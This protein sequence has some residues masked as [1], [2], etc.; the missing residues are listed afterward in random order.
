MHQHPK[1]ILQLLFG[2]FCIFIVIKVLV[3]F[4]LRQAQ[5]E[6]VGEIQEQGLDTGALF[7]SNSEE[8]VEANFE[9]LKKN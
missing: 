5:L 2:L 7:Y 4:V 8:A 1:P 3:P 9:M 6:W